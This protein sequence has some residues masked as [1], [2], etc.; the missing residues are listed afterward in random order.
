MEHLKYFNELN[1]S[2]STITEEQVDFLNEYTIGKWK[3]TI[4]GMID[5]IGDFDCSKS[6]LSDFNGIVFNKVTGNFNCSHN[7]LATLEG[8]PKEVTREFNC[9]HNIL[10]TLKGG[11]KKTGDFRCQS[12]K[13]KDLRGGPKEVTGSYNVLGNELTSVKGAPKK[14]ESYFNCSEFEILGGG[15]Y[16]P[17]PKGFKNVLKYKG[18]IEAKKLA[19]TVLNAD[20]FNSEI[21]KNPLQTMKILRNVWDE[22]F[23][24]RMKNKLIIPEKYREGLDIYFDLEKLGF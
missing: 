13:L 17:Y 22:A 15:W 12:N 9:D 21:E 5:V 4:K 24:Q 7:I 1:E 20:Y 3:E 19:M 23:F 2:E 16:N 11:P 14:L 18:R 8:A 6:E 10:T